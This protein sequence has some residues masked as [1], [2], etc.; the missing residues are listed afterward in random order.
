MPRKTG[1]LV[2]VLVSGRLEVLGICFIE[3][4]TRWR[5]Q[6][7]KPCAQVKIVGDILDFSLL[8]TPIIKFVRATFKASSEVTSVYLHYHHPR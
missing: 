6:G 7:R 1:F 5:E 4:G 3:F 2:K 8:R